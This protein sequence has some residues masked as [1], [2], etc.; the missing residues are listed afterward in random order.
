VTVQDKHGKA[1]LDWALQR[2]HIE[3]VKV[4]QEKLSSIN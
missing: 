2:R 4:L 1:A 3:V